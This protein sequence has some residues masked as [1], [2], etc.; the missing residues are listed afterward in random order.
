MTQTNTLKIGEAT[1][2]EKIN[3]KK[4]NYI[5]NNRSKYE[6]IIL[7]QEKDMRRL[8]KNY[9]A[10]VS[11]QKIANN[12]FIPTELEGTEYALI[13]VSY[14]KGEKSNGIGRWYCS[15]GIGLQPLCC[16]VRHTICEGI[17]VDI[18][19]VNSHPTIFKTFMEKYGFTSQLLDECLNNREVFLKK[20]IEAQKDKK[21]SR[22]TAKTMVIALIN[23]NKYN[24]NSILNTLLEQIQ[25]CIDY[26]INLPEYA[27]ILSYVKEHYPE[28]KN[29]SGKTISRILQ[30][31]ENDLLE[32]YIE[33]F[34]ERGYIGEKN[35][36][37][38]IFDGFQILTENNITD[39]MLEE[40]REYAL[41]KTGYDIPLKIKPFDNKL[42]LPDNYIECE[43]DLPALLNKYDTGLQF[44]VEK[45]TSLF[46]AAINNNNQLSV[47]YVGKALLKDF[48]YYDD[49]LKKWYYC[50]VNNIWKEALEPLMLKG[51]LQVVLSRAFLIYSSSLTKSVYDGTITDE[52][53]KQIILNDASKAIKIA[54]QLGN[55]KYIKDICDYKELY[56]KDKFGEKL[57]D[58]KPYLYAFSNKVFDFKI[59]KLRNIKPDDY[60]MTN[61]EYEYPEYIDK[62]DTDFLENYFTTLF[63][64]VELRDYVLDS[65]ASTIN[66][67][68]TEQYFNI[69]T[70][71]GSN[72]KTT[73]NNLFD[74]VLGGY[75]CR[76]SAETFTKP[77][78]GSNDT[79]E[80]YKAK[81]KRAV[82]TNEP[83]SDNDNKLQTA[84]LK[85]VAD[86]KNQKLIARCLYANPIE[87]PITFQLNIFCNH[88]PELNSADD[89]IG[90]RLRIINYKVKFVNEYPEDYD[91]NNKYIVL[92]NTDLMDKMTTDGV[93]NAFIILLLNRWTNRVSKMKHIPV[94]KQ[95]QEASKEFVED[96]NPVLGFIQEYYTITNIEN[97][98][99]QS[100]KL[101]EEFQA[102]V[103]DRKITSK[104]FKDDMLNIGGIT[105]KIENTGR[106]FRGLKKKPEQ[107]INE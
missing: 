63:P 73:F 88:K 81:G 83:E 54:T 86:E 72:S 80:L 30:V 107:V 37:A 18:D 75:A 79:G 68:K 52:S 42:D 87:F 1:F 45:N 99:V 89:G 13:K 21:Y 61:T 70:G 15:K 29:I 69:H 2:Y 26:V 56:L 53:M 17:W 6:T 38:L 55:K 66:G 91:P 103:S 57:I 59:N 7:E 35:E 98:K 100:K 20:V 96:C 41:N 36:V 74:T 33:W 14:K 27:E 104:R 48:T 9:N 50:N 97:D 71:S 5:I 11:F 23:G 77:K 95:V 47:A 16:S 34:N 64:D 106:F 8:D 65:C 22:D 12:C 90:R 25:P 44:F 76:V 40:C 31:I 49:W 43:D 67:N 24:Q 85:R 3:I 19:Q 51:I 94:P 4:L 10:Y 82:F 60:I 92:K 105:Y 58:N 46:K 101:Y 78:K 28:D 32:T 93:R 62:E 84:I 102:E 39:E